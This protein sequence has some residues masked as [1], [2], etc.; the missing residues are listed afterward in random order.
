MHNNNS[1]KNLDIIEIFDILGEFMLS[2]DMKE[3]FDFLL[4][5]HVGIDGINRLESQLA[6]DKDDITKLKKY[7]KKHIPKLAANNAFRKESFNRRLICWLNCNGL[8]VVSQ[9]LLKF[10]LSARRIFIGP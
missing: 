4:I 9:D 5:N 1:K 2:R 6:P 10:K 8:H 3:D 7:M